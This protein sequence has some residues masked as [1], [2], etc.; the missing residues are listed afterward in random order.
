MSLVERE[1][2]Q[3][4][5]QAFLERARQLSQEELVVAVKALPEEVLR[6]YRRLRHDE[7][8]SSAK[9]LE[10]EKR[11]HLSPSAKYKLVVTPYATKAGCWNYTQGLVYHRGDDKPLAEIRR[12]YSSFPHSWVEGHQNGHDYLVA[13][14]DYQGQ[15]VIELD[16]G[17]RRD[18]LSKGAEQGHGFCWAE[19]RFA[20]SQQVLIVCG[21]I[22]ACPYEFR[23]YDFSDPVHGWPE[24]ELE[25]PQIID[26]DDKWPV[27]LADGAVLS[28]QTLS[29]DDEDDD[30][31]GEE[32][33][34]DLPP[35]PRAQGEERAIIT[36]RREGL[37]LLF[38][39]EW[40]SDA[41]QETRRKREEGRI[42]YEQ[43][44]ETFRTSDPLYLA[45]V[46]L[47]KDPALSPDTYESVGV[48]HDRWCPDF[49]L[50]EQRWCRRI[51]G[52]NSG[53]QSPPNH[54]PKQTWTV[55]LEWA[56]ATGPIKLDIYKHGSAYAEKFFEHSVV[57]MQEAFAYVKK[58]LLRV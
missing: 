43:K 9:A 35:K 57:G 49:K 42:A 53:G 50:Q 18:Q 29:T 41:E 54:P 22:W 21:C 11:E 25:P 30:E 7:L 40:V 52:S 46:D 32:E 33:G 55:D 2:V 34:E 19:H 28:Y 56:M 24:I 44:I 17:R 13:G 37:K 8:F 38:V 16:T 10:A 3:E 15:T 1:K 23:L 12:N 14:E 58:E 4:L 5:A 45:Y 6:R 27:V 39:S 36:Y 31:V 47:V 48:T 20:A 26:G 51:V